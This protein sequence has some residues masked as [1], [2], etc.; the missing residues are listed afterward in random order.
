MLAEYSQCV[1]E[2]IPLNRLIYITEKLAHL[3]LSA[4]ENLAFPTFDIMTVKH[5]YT[6]FSFTTSL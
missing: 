2:K 6:M 1:L 3:A 4:Q 5:L